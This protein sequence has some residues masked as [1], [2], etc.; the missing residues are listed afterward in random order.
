MGEPGDERGHAL[1]GGLRSRSLCVLERLAGLTL[2]PGAGDARECD[3]LAIPICKRNEEIDRWLRVEIDPKRG[4]ASP[5]PASPPQQATPPL[6]LPSPSH[7]LHHELSLA[8]LALTE[9]RPS[10][11][12][13]SSSE[14]DGSDDPFAFESP[15]SPDAR[16][17]HSS[18]SLFFDDAFGGF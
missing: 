8:N 1:F 9:T 16:W 11:H 2:I 6:L 18:G 17:P 4:P 7:E 15:I 3:A 12:L 5:R 10:P 13:P 14:D